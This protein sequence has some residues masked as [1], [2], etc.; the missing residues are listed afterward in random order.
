MFVDNWTKYEDVNLVN[1]RHILL[2]VSDTSDEEAMSEA[3][4]QAEDI[5]DEYLAGDQT[6]DAFAALAQQYSADGSASDGGLIED[7]T[8][9]QMVE[10]FE[11]WCFDESRQPGDTGIVESEFGYHVMYFVSTGENWKDYR[12]ANAMRTE[13]ANAWVEELAAE[14]PVTTQSFGMLFVG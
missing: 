14:L 3:E 11:D 12:I 1:V 8:P 9:G 2:S 10:P 13:D 6:E 7:I 4:L 5:L